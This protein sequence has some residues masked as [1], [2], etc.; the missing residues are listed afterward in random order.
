MHS[1]IYLFRIALLHAALFVASMCYAQTPPN[2]GAI[3][4]DEAPLVAPVPKAP[5]TLPRLSEPMPEGRVAQPIEIKSINI[6]GTTVFSSA[7]LIPLLSDVASGSHTLGELRRAATRI[8]QHY[9]QAGYFLARAY[10]PKQQILDGVLTI[11]VLE[12][13]LEKGETIAKKAG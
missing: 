8:T 11:A 10:L 5:V 2:A 6:T 3:L 1:K 9:R 7:E 4:R 13:K 12:G